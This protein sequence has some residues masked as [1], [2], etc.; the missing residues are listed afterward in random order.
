[1]QNDIKIK[2]ALSGDKNIIN[3]ISKT[4]NIKIKPTE[5]ESKF[6]IVDREQILFYISKYGPGRDL[7]IWLN[8][9][10]FSESFATLFEKSLTI[11]N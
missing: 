11:N 4:L 7:A 3:N 8:S 1:M 6:F 5:I 10:F 2:I 9:K